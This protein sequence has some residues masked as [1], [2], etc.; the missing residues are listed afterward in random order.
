MALGSTSST[1]ILLGRTQQMNSICSFFLYL[2]EMG[3]LIRMRSEIQNRKK[4]WNCPCSTICGSKLRSFPTS[5]D[6]QVLGERTPDCKYVLDHMYPSL[7]IWL[8][9]ELKQQGAAGLQFQW[10]LWFEY[11]GSSKAPIESAVVMMASEWGLKC[12]PSQGTE[13]ILRKWAI[14]WVDPWCFGPAAFTH[15]L[16]AFYCPRKQHELFTK[17]PANNI[18]MGLKSQNLKHDSCLLYFS[19][20]AH[21]AFTCFYWI[22]KFEEKIELSMAPCKYVWNF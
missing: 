13:W 21:K 22:Q 3:S 5:Q 2:C 12:S 14:M 17:G 15:C 6:I 9:Y 10:L 7:Q 1:V 19:I 8:R 11:T 18:S 16:S 4:H 20:R